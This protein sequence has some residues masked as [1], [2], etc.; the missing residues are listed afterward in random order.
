MSSPLS[1]RRS[2]RN[3]RRRVA[4]YADVRDAR[5]REPEPDEG[6]GSPL[7]SPTPGGEGEEGDD[8][9]EL[10]R[11]PSVTRAFS[12]AAALV[13]AGRRRARIVSFVDLLHLHPLKFADVTHKSTSFL[14]LCFNSPPPTSSESEKYSES[15]R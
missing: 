12:R 15:V 13:V 4:G 1:P 6:P 14:T 2:P 10:P 5:E 8:V 11:S 7:P 3:Q 9:F